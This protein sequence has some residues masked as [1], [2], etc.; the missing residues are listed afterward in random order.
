MNEGMNIDHYFFTLWK[1]YLGIGL[2]M[3]RE[4]WCHF[5]QIHSSSDYFLFDV[6]F[7]ITLSVCIINHRMSFSSRRRNYLLTPH[8]RDGLIEWWAC[9]DNCIVWC[10]CLG[11]DFWCILYSSLTTTHDTTEQRVITHLPFCGRWTPKIQITIT[12]WSQC[13]SIL[14][15]WM[16]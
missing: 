2:D 13:C 5:E 11:N 6:P 7:S 12:G 4:R 8:R 9:I 14:L 3:K 10:S 16:R 1:V 15:S